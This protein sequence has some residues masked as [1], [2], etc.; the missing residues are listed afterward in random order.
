MNILKH[1]LLIK[2]AKLIEQDRTPLRWIDLYAAQFIADSFIPELITSNTKR[3]SQQTVTGVSTM[4]DLFEDLPETQSYLTQE[5]II[6]LALMCSQLVSQGKTHLNLKSLPQDLLT[7][8]KACGYRP[9][10]TSSQEL[11]TILYKMPQNTVIR[12]VTLEDDF[13]GNN[14][15]LEDSESV[16]QVPLVVFQDRLFLANIGLYIKALKHG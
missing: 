13:D 6:V 2:L 12:F 10:Y 15:V 16:K 7:S 1:S 5:D 9:G 14:L 11:I 3:V 8:A 4:A